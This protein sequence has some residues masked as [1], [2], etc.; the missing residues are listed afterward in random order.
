MPGTAPRAKRCGSS[1]ASRSSTSRGTH[2]ELWA[3]YRAFGEAKVRYWRATGERPNGRQGVALGG[4]LAALLAGGL[5]GR[6]P[7]RLVAALVAALGVLA[8]VD[9]SVDPE[10][11]DVGTRVAAIGAYATFLSGWC[12]GI[13]RGLARRAGPRD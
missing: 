13:V 3:Q 9:H 6:R 5:V 10:D 8:L 7:R 4:A 1:P 12:C 2:R 11:R